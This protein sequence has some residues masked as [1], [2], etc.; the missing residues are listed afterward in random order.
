MAYIY[1]TLACDQE[2]TSWTIHKLGMEVKAVPGNSVKIKGGAGLADKNL[3]TPHGVV[4]T[5]TD[6]ELAL[7]KTIDAFNKHVELGYLTIDDS[8]SDAEVVAADMSRDD[9][10]RPLTPQEYDLGSDRIADNRG[11]GRGKA[12]S[13]ASKG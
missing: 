11:N 10:S 8:K 3:H 9:K 5:V 6:D 2:Y 13:A 1:S 7:L 12:P 4:T